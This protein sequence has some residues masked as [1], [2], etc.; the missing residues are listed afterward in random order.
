MAAVI[1]M[2]VLDVRR[3]DP[4][5]PLCTQHQ[6]KQH[7][8]IGGFIEDQ[9]SRHKEHHNLTQAQAPA[10]PILMQLGPIFL[11]PPPLGRRLSG[12]WKA[13]ST[14]PIGGAASTSLSVA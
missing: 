6:F 13:R 3:H 9:L 11:N 12:E 14:L 2:Q 8:L 10:K 4:Q 7:L 5:E 1:D